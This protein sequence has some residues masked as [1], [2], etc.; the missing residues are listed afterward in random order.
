MIL[1][2]AASQSMGGNYDYGVN[3]P[4]AETGGYG[5]G[6]FIK[7]IGEVIRGTNVSISGDQTIV[8]VGGITYSRNKKTGE[9]KVINQTSMA[10]SNSQ[11]T[12]ENNP[13]KN[14]ISSENGG[15]L[16]ILGAAAVAA[17]FLLR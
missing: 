11:Q 2:P 1:A 12:Y 5:V 9:T 7:D 8:T 17:F 13:F 6:D 4:K 10:G 15:M 16:L 14:F 3:S